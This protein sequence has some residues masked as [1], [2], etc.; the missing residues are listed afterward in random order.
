[1]WWVD[2]DQQPS[3]HIG[4]CS[5]PSGMEERAGRRRGHDNSWVEIKTAYNMKERGGKKKKE[6]DAKAVTQHLPQAD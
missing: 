3:T 1:M 4:V 5:L 6:G 2:P